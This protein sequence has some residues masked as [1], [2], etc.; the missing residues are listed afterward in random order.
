MSRN[1]EAAEYRIRAAELSPKD[2]SLVVAAATA[3]RLLDRA[4]D[5]EKWYRQVRDL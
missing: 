2:Y 3:L 5:A 4:H 1:N